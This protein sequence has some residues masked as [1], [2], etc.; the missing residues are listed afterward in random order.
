MPEDTALVFQHL[1]LATNRLVVFGQMRAAPGSSRYMASTSLE[2]RLVLVALVLCWL[3]TGLDFC[4]ILYG[5]FLFC[6]VAVAKVE[7]RSRQMVSQTEL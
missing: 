7:L 4:T 2:H 1:V 5:F 6:V 3:I